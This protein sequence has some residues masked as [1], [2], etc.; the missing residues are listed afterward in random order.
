MKGGIIAHLQYPYVGGESQSFHVAHFEI[1]C[2]SNE[3]GRS[4][5]WKL[6]EKP[7]YA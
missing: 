7:I 3:S 2:R 4:A 6:Y 1:T 5:L